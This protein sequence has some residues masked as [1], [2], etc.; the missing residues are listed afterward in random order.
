MDE[1]L[2]GRPFLRR[3]GFD[4]KSHLRTVATSLHDKDYSE[5]DSGKMK[6]SAT[7][8]RGFRYDSISDDPISITE[9]VGASMGIDKDSE[10]EIAFTKMK[11]QGQQNGLSKTGQSVLSKL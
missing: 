9:S 4:L 1:I 8:Y 2:L 10:M 7:R 5:I 3:I 6:L 11:K